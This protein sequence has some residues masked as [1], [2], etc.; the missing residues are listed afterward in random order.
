L[1]LL[2][3]KRMIQDRHPGHFRWIL[4]REQTPHADRKT[5]FAAARHHRE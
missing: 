1:I 3:Q 5:Y 4:S 2:G